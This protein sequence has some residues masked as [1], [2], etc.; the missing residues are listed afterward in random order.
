MPL[1]RYKVRDKEGKIISG[2]LEGT[3]LNTTGKCTALARTF[4][5]ECSP[6]AR[7]AVHKNNNIM[8]AFQFDLDMRQREFSQFNMLLHGLIT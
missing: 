5:I 8:A 2:S 6:H 4:Q 3:D 7:E 1:F